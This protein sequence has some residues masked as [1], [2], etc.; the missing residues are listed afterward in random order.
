MLQPPP[1]PPAFLSCRT[2]E[3]QGRN[4]GDFWAHGVAAPALRAL[5]L[6]TYPPELLRLLSPAESH[7]S[8]FP[9]TAEEGSDK[10][11][12]PPP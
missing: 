10:L 9:E 12:T 6:L 2:A 11:L 8:F 4:D 7:P 3:K 1:P 5:R